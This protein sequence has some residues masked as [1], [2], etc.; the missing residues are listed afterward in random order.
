MLKLYQTFLRFYDP[1]QDVFRR[2]E[3]KI[4]YIA[5][6]TLDQAPDRHLYQM[7]AETCEKISPWLWKESC[8]STGVR[9]PGNTCASPTSMI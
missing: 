3:A 2:K 9:K 7:S 1:V 8:V 6:T 5:D 4:A